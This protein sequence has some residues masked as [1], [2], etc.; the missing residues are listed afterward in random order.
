MQQQYDTFRPAEYTLA[1]NASADERAAFIRRTYLHLAG[2]IAAFTMLEGLLLS[3]PFAGQLAATMTNGMTW[4]LVL[5]A[6]IA[7]SYVAQNWATSATSLGT[8][9]AGLGLFVF[10]EAIIFLPLLYV[11]AN[12]GGPQVIPTAAIVTGCIFLGLTSS[13]FFIR[14]NLSFLGPYLGLAGF[15][16]L[17][18]IVC[19]ILFG[20]ELGMF[21]TGAMIAFAALYVVYQT[22]NILH[23]FRT[24]QHV[25]ASL[26]LFA[27]VALLFWYVLRL[28]MISR[29]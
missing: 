10:A 11:A 27:S 17:G 20:F 2:A 23:E 8:Q 9:Y 24:D 21:F 13:M 6:F 28:L 29:D 5:G 7:V 12:F 1:D 25:A 18:I 14:P 4:L 19:G 22:S 15:A 3:M 16:A 26:A